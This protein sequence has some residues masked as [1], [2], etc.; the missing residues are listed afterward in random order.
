MLTEPDT[1]VVTNLHPSARALDQHIPPQAQRIHIRAP[2][3]VEDLLRRID[4]GLV[5]V[6]A[7]VQH[8]VHTSPAPEG[9]DQVVVEGIVSPLHAR[10]GDSLLI[11]SVDKGPCLRARM[12]TRPV[13]CPSRRV[14]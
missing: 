12:L 9:I 4:D 11:A 10:Y 1:K 14:K 6:E 3:A 13:S 7:G 2:E 8:Y 5:L